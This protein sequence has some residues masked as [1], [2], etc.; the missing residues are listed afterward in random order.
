MCVLLNS[1]N[2]KLQNLQ[3]KFID[4]ENLTKWV[5]YFL[6]LQILVAIVSMLFGFSEYNLLSDI[7]NGVLVVENEIL[8]KAES[9][10]QYRQ[11]IAIIYLIIFV[12]SGVLI[13]KWIHRANHNVRQ[14]GAKHLLFTPGWSI[15]WYFIPFA[16][17]WK[18][19][20]AMKEIWKASNNP[21]DWET[22][23]NHSIVNLWWTLWLLSNF[24]GQLG[25][26]LSRKAEDIDAYI[27]VNIISQ[28][29]DFLDIP[30]ALVLLLLV[31]KIY[32]NQ[33]KCY[34]EQQL[35]SNKTLEDYKTNQ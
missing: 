17:F 16:A 10:D 29:S 28:I 2:L 25:F 3:T 8:Q 7:N 11:I 19:F 18:P 1:G 34:L 33:K 27:Q 31:T 20:Q 32:N 26:R 13:L 21:S 4:S 35:Y 30:L 5:K 12:I 23:D 9:I 15:G 22:V 6:Y 14:L 24:I